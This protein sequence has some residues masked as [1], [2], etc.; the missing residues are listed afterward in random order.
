M[1]LLK[2][3]M[4]RNRIAMKVERRRIQ[5]H[6][7]FSASPSA[8]K[9]R[10]KKDRVHPTPMLSDAFI[11]AKFLASDLE[12]EKKR[13]T[14]EKSL[15]KKKPKRP[16]SPRKP[17]PTDLALSQSRSSSRT[18]ASRVPLDAS[19]SPSSSPDINDKTTEDVPPP[20]P[21]HLFPPVSVV[22][23]RDSIASTSVTVLQ[24]RWRQRK[25]RL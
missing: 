2:P 20:P 21:S 15:E 6:T 18:S 12:K 5:W 3:M 24:T 10:S 19:S 14:K 7:P 22:A 11:A 8:D 25:P 17:S 4:W 16:S 23:S 9:K 13:E 1:L